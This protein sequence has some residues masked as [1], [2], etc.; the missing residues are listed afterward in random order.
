MRQMRGKERGARGWAQGARSKEQGAGGRGLGVSLRLLGRGRVVLALLLALLLVACSNQAPTPTAPANATADQAPKT[1]ATTPTPAATATPGV[2]LTEGRIVLWHS[3][4][5]ADGDALAAILTSFKQSYPKL[6]VDTLFVDYNDLPQSYAEA[7][8]ANGGPDLILASNAWLGDMVKANVVQP[9]DD[10]LP[11]E[12]LAAYWPATLDNLRWQGKLYG[13]PTNFELVSLYYNR[14]LVSSD[15]LPTKIADLLA[16][17]RDNPRQGIGLYASLYHLYWALPAF[18]VQLLD[19]NGKAQLDHNNGA[20]AFLQWLVDTKKQPGS[21]V[22]PDY[23]MLM[24]RFKKGEYAFFVDGPWSL[25]ELHNAMGDR[26]GVTALPAGPAGPARPWLTADGIFINPHSKQEQQQRALF[27]AKYLTSAANGEVLAKTARRLPAN[28]AAQ[29][30]DD[31][32]LQSFMQQA[33]TA[34]SLPSIPEMQEVWGYGGDMLLK[35]IHDEDDLTKVV[36]ETTTLINEA[37]GK[38]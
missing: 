11:S 15:K 10:L 3:W 2:E 1:N 33:A 38:K 6:K 24:D 5:E 4:S 7:V 16:L 17:A 21:F 26:L 31:S 32:L 29:I 22:D 34:E 8:K 14:G 25:D 37:N 18:G 20:V 27:F 23:S 36:T 30:Q 35:A 9:L 19:E 13:I 28:R 12:D